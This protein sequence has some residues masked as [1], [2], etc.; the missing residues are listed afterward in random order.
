MVK[1]HRQGTNL[2]SFRN[3]GRIGNPA[4]AIYMA[5]RRDRAFAITEIV[6]LH[7]TVLYP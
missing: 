4:I 6:L 7:L 3:L 5:M 1:H 2:S